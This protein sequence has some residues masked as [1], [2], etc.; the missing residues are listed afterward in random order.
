M[1]DLQ[2]RSIVGAGLI[3]LAVGALWLG[4]VAFWLMTVVGGLVMMAEWTNLHG[5][6]VRTRRLGQFALSVPLAVLSP[7]AAGPTPFV[8]G[9]LAGAGFFISAVC[10]RSAL[11]WGIIYVGLPVF[12][13]VLL[14]AQVPDDRG[15]LL[16]FWAMGLVWATD[17]GAYFAG[18][19]IG[20]AKLAPGISP[21][22]TWAGLIGGLLSATLFAF[23]LHV[24]LRLPFRLVL[25]TPLL[26]VLAQAGDLFE[27]WLKRRAGVKDSGSIL[28][29]HGGLLDRMDGLVPVA[30]VAALIVTLPG[31]LG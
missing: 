27:S 1:S 30:P 2:R 23:L 29:G 14:R 22:K 12:A 16:A 5:V 3:V 21:N 6:D 17:I 7:I 20:G 24:E 15:L 10:R 9:L 8:I 26:A 11:G 4:G 31:W 18:R 19:A 28:P 13:L 25:A